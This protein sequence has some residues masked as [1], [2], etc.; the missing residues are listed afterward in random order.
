MTS[1]KQ[2]YKR[3]ILGVGEIIDIN[4]IGPVQAKIDS[5]NE[6]FNVLHGINIKDENNEV[7]FTTV[8]NKSIKKPKYDTITIHIGS[9]VKEDRPVVLF[10]IKVD[11]KEYKDIPFSIADR[12]E[13]DEPVLVG[14]PFVQQLNAL[15]DVKKDNTED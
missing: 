4:G 3:P 7:S 9:G 1:F 14:E 2:F 10:D 8:D 13:N 11:G 12:T 6:A 15:I 5:G